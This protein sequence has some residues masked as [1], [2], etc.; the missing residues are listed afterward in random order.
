MMIKFICGLCGFF[1]VAKGYARLLL[2][3]SPDRRQGFL[4]SPVAVDLINFAAVMALAAIFFLLLNFD[5]QW[6]LGSVLILSLLAYDW[7]ARCVFL[8]WE[9]RRARRSTS[10]P[11]RQA[12]LQ[13]VCRRAGY[14][15]PATHW[16]FGN[17]HHE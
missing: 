13:R 16:P 5:G 14:P 12:A 15:L 17:I 8:E 4:N 7:V 6:V 11:T 2:V 10:T 3:R 9:V 1:I